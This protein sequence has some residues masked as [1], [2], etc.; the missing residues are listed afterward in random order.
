MRNAGP[1]EQYFNVYTRTGL[2]SWVVLAARY[3]SS[4]GALSCLTD[5]PTLF[6]A[7]EKVVRC[8]AA[9]HARLPPPG[10]SPR[11]TRLSS[12]DLN[13][14]VHFIQK[15][16]SDLQ[17]IIE[18]C[19]DHYMD[20]SE[21]KPRWRLLV[22]RDGTLVF[23]WDHSIG[24]GQSGLAFHRALLD[25]LNSVPELPASH[26]GVITPLPSDLALPTSLEDAAGR[27]ISVPIPMLV[28]VLAEE[29]LPFLFARKNAAT[30]TGNPVPLEP[31]LHTQ[32]RILHYSPSDTYTLLRAARARRATLTGTLHTLALVVLSRLIRALLNGEELKFKAIATFIPIS[33]RRHTGTH[34]TEICVQVTHYEGHQAMLLPD[35]GDFPW[36]VAAEF[37]GTLQRAIVCAGPVTGMLKYL[38]G[39]YEEYL[40]GHLGKKRGWGLELSNLGPFP[41]S[42][43]SGTTDLEKS[44]DGAGDSTEVLAARWKIKEMTFAQAEVLGSALKL[45]VVGSPEG[46][47][48]MT[49]SWGT[50]A[51]DKELAEAFVV[52]LHDGLRALIIAAS[53]LETRD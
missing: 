41:G 2:C 29:Y 28:R 33:M 10:E 24:D 22:L 20:I 9:L 13:E 48:G 23:L 4:L 25:A 47:L 6:A 19:F 17:E 52:G 31:S 5:K 35:T 37:T 36:D 49:V 44:E 16:H 27:Q 14:V 34:A 21:D 1:I 53:D 40:E 46:G 30:W 7:L 39:R 15:D 42:P 12:V 50:S 18:G 43:S 38:F 11:W 8:H 51:V 32:V 26:S 45:N 3:E